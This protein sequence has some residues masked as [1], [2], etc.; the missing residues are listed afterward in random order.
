MLGALLNIKLNFSTAYHPET[1]GQT[2]RTNQTLEVYLRMYTSYQQDDW[3]DHLPVAEFA[4]NNAPHSATQVSSFFANYGYNPRTTLNLD[5][6]VPDPT[7]HDFA[8]SLSHLHEYCKSQIAIAQVQYQVP[9]DRHRRPIPEEMV[10][11]SKVWLNA[12]N[13]KTKRP[14]KKLD[15]KKLGPFTIEKKISSHAFRLALPHGLRL[16]HPVFHV[17]LLEPYRENTIANRTQPPPLPVEVDG[18]TEYE[19]SAILDSRI[20]RRKLQYLVQWAGYE[21]TAEAISWESP[22]NVENSPLLVAQF[23]AK[24][25]NKPRPDT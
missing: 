8:Q 3:V 21:G 12:K 11:G 1:D 9:A 2:E 10:E 15:H 23:H 22:E 25:P 18:T 19:V 4:Y 6:T 24:Y 7:A 13:I 20:H 16:L 5:V 14:S 17:S